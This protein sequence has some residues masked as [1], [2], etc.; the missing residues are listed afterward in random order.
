MPHLVQMD[1]R[2]RK[3]GLHVIG[4]EV[5]GSSPEDIAKVV[6]DQDM[7]FTVTKGINGPIQVGGIPHMVVFDTSG[8]LVFRGHPMDDE[9]EKSIKR[10][11]RDVKESGIGTASAGSSVFAKPTVLIEER[12]WTNAEGKSIRAAITKVDG[13]KIVFR[14]GN[15]RDVPYP[16]ANLSEADQALLEELLAEKKAESGDDDG[17]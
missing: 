11:L 14:M 13:D 10:A 4:A 3:K 9:A 16:I 17:A 12:T 2:N 5:Q 8:K 6:K 15:G 7:E 1:K